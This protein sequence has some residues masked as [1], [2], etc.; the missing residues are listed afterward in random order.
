MQ[1]CLE[2]RPY[3]GINNRDL[4]HAGQVWQGEAH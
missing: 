1:G 2:F 3:Y 4:L